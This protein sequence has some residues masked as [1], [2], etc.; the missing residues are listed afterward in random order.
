MKLARLLTIILILA[1]SACASHRVAIP[2]MDLP[3]EPVKPKIVST[4]IMQGDKAFVGYTVPD[5]LKL[6][7]YLEEEELLR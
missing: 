4:V 7:R 6:Y 2:K 5:S 1:S 3:P